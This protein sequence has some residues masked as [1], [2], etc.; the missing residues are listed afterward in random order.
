MLHL[1]AP[2]YVCPTT[3]SYEHTRRTPS[4]GQAVEV[5]HRAIGQQPS[6]SLLSMGDTT[7]ISVREKRANHRMQCTVHTA[8]LTLLPTTEVITSSASVYYI[9]ICS[10]TPL[11]LS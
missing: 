4:V 2:A 1:F 7:R 8:Q 3:S 10:R 6:L 5:G 11:T 9:Y